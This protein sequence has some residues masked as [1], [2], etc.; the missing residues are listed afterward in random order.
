MAVFASYAG[1]RLV[2]ARLTLPP[3]GAWT[4]DLLLASDGEVPTT[5]ALVI[6]NLT[7]IGA[8][9]PGRDG[10]FAGSRTVRLVGGAG[11]WQRTIGARFYAKT[12]G[13]RLAT[14]I[15]DAAA[16][17]GETVAIGAAYSSRVAGLFWS[18]PAGQ[19]VNVLANTVQRAWWIDDAGVTQIGD[20]PTTYVRSPFDLTGPGYRGDLAQVTI[21]T[22]DPLS[23]RPGAVF[24]SELLPR[25][26]QAA[27]VSMHMAADGVL[28]A[29]VLI[30]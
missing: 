8:V 5:G 15:T 19:A 28:R 30:S 29:E 20:R 17:V 1:S 4:A 3:W 27:S 6:G 14:I 7:L 11:G 26:L 24:R 22:E 12:Q 23:W 16:E 25:P 21:A 2:T 18:R 9:L 13:V 10:P